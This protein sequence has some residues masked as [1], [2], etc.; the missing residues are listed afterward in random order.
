MCIFTSKHE[1]Y[2][3]DTNKQMNDHVQSK[4]TNNSFTNKSYKNL[5]DQELTYT[6]IVIHNNHYIFLIQK[7]SVLRDS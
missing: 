6:N 4:T 1:S 5:K 3:Y 7:L 2:L